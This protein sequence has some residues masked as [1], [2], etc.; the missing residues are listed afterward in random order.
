[1][2]E[3]TSDG[4]SDPL[5]ESA[6]EV[7]TVLA[8][9]TKDLCKI[10]DHVT[11]VIGRLTFPDGA[12]TDQS[13]RDTSHKLCFE[14]MMRLYLYEEVCGF[15]QSEV[16]RRLRS[17]P[18]L[19]TRFGVD[20]APTQPAISYFQRQRLS[21]KDQ[22]TLT[23]LS[24]IIQQVASEHDIIGAPNKAPPIQPEERVNDGLTEEDIL[25]AVRIARDRVFTEFSTNRAANAKYDDEVFWELQAYLSM[26]AHGGRETKRRS[27]RLSW[28]SEMPHGDT[29]TRTLKKMG[30]PNS[31]TALSDFGGRSRPAMWRRIRETLLDPFDKAIENLIE[32]TN[33]GDQLRE[34]VNVA[35]DVT[36]WRFYPSPWKYKHLDI[37]KEDY[38]EMVSGLKD[39]HERGYKFFHAHRNWR[40]YSDNLGSRA[41]QG[42]VSVGKR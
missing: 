7:V 35:I 23:K 13:T 32:E 6:S 33:F 9:Q 26:T 27:T 41:G 36:P 20:R 22:H 18:Y 3:H 1:M 40:E 42:T 37:L 31:Q 5:P 24:K 39:K 10:H 4:L 11:R 2:R 16:H 21:M 17:W 29:H 28:R 12:F 34:P 30:S 15:S 14:G 19:L 8:Q 38:P 25:R